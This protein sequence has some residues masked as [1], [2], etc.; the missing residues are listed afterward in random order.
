MLSSLQLLSKYLSRVGVRGS[1]NDSKLNLLQKLIK[2][3]PP[4]EYEIVY[5][6]LK[7]LYSSSDLNSRA[8]FLSMLIQDFGYDHSEIE[9]CISNLH[10]IDGSK[11]T[12]KARGSVRLRQALIPGYEQMFDQVK[13][14]DGGLFWLV[15][16]RGDALELRSR[17]SSFQILSESLKERFHQWFSPKEVVLDQITWKSPAAVLEKVSNRVYLIN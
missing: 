5:D 15:Q 3:Y 2:R 13:W 1:V 10:H 4:V 7:T 9:K 8:E 17:D 12:A 11:I 16:M 14:I 6:E